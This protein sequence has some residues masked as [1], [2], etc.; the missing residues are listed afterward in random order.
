MIGSEFII[1]EV[2]GGKEAETGSARRGDGASVH[3][4]ASLV[5]G[6][7]GQVFIVGRDR[8]WRR[9]S[10]WRRSG[11]WRCGAGST[12][13]SRVVC[14]VFHDELGTAAFELS[15][16]FPCGLVARVAAPLHKVLGDS[17]VGAAVEELVGKILIILELLR[18]DLGVIRA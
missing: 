3:P 5:L 15:A 13:A 2:A 8:R 7:T 4:T 17:T 14:I 6:H 16:G 18:V 1:G 9:R 11:G 12:A 10:W